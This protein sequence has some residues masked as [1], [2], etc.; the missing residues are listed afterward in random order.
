MIPLIPN[1]CVLLCQLRGMHLMKHLREKL[2]PNPIMFQHKSVS[3]WPT[4]A[5]GLERDSL[6]THK[7]PFHY[8]SHLHLPDK[9]IKL[10]LLVN[11]HAKQLLTLIVFWIQLKWMV[12]LL[13]QRWFKNSVWSFFKKCDNQMSQSIIIFI[14]PFPEY[15]PC[16]IEFAPPHLRTLWEQRNMSFSEKKPV[17][18]F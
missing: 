11:T 9:K 1:T 8:Q 6:C 14:H 5:L 10:K 16:F 7:I 13:H 4:N 12:Q 17:I 2:I 3:K 15:V 18:R